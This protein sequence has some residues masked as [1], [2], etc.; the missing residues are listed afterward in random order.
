MRISFV[1]LFL[2]CGVGAFAEPLQQPRK[3]EVASADSQQNAGKQQRGTEQLPV[4]VKIIPPEKTK[5]EAAADVKEKEE[6]ITKIT[7]WATIIST[8]LTLVTLGV[9]LYQTRLTRQSLESAIKSYEQDKRVR[10][11][12]S[13]PK[14]YF[15]ID[16]QV[17]IEKWINDYEQ[18]IADLKTA[19]KTNDDEILR[20]LSTKGLSTPKNLVKKYIYENAPQWISVLLMTAAQY[21]FD[22]MAP[23]LYV[24]DASKKVGNYSL[25][26]ELLVEFEAHKRRLEEI[27]GFFGEMIP[28]ACLESPASIRDE[29]FLTDN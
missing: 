13:L 21:Y 5:V 12:E 29:N 24:W 25:S 3:Q 17:T 28:N 7:S 10:Q 6:I 27:Y 18:I 26:N 1:V 14:I 8:V 20:K 16:A 11:I 23:L 9:V 15:V 22:R 19:V 4:Y 2:L